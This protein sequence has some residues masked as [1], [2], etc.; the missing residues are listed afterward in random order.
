[1]FALPELDDAFTDRI[2][3]LADRKDGKGLTEREGPFRIIVP[4]EK[5]PARWVRQVVS[6]TIRQSK[7]DQP[8]PAPA[9]R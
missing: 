5:R 7:K 4:H 3:L 6:L 9:T 2:V 8:P 1:V